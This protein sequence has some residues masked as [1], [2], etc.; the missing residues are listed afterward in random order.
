MTSL[1]PPSRERRKLPAASTVTRRRNRIAGTVDRLDD[2]L[3]A[4]LRRRAGESPIDLEEG[5]GLGAVDGYAPGG[6]NTGRGSD[7]PDPTFAR[8]DTVAGGRDGQPDK[9]RTPP[10]P[11]GDAIVDILDNL[12]QLDRL[13]AS[14]DRLIDYVLNT[15]KAN[16]G[17][18]SSIDGVC[19]VCD[20]S[21]TGIGNDRLKCGYCPTD[22][23]AWQRSEHYDAGEHLRFRRQRRR[24]LQ[25]RE[26]GAA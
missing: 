7:T 11:V 24:D 12:R 25:A 8:V 26:D 22:Y 6:D 1:P 18:Q 19:L 20:A 21:V 17:R 14:T 13:A 3:L 23:K 9:W 4:E 15:E 16:R 10:D 2:Q 5:A